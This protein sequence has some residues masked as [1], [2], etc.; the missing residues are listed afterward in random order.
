MRYDLCHGILPSKK[1]ECSA[2]SCALVMMAML[3]MLF[4]RI[5]HKETYLLLS[6]EDIEE[7]LVSVLPLR[8]M[9]EEEIIFQLE[10]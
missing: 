5:L 9:K 7:L 10:Q 4:E 1:I 2:P 6:C 3:F 8:N